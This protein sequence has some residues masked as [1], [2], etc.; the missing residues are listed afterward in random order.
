MFDKYMK[1]FK[2]KILNFM[3]FMDVN[4]G[5]ILYSEGN[6]AESLYFLVTGSFETFKPLVITQEN[7]S[8]IITPLKYV[9]ISI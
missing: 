9:S 7:G 2:V 1:S 6:K 5:E 8:S 4:K 3:E